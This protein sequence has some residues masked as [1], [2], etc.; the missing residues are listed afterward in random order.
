MAFHWSEAPANM[1]TN[2]AL[3]PMAKI[4]EYKV[5]SVKAVLDVLDRACRDNMFL[6]ALMENP[7]GTLKDYDLTEEHRTALANGDI[8][9]IE[10]WV[11]ILDPRLR[12]WIKSRLGQENWE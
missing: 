7:I 3:D 11:G 10:Q 9:K 5:A 8:P 2:A 4:P 12:D 6:K 1:L